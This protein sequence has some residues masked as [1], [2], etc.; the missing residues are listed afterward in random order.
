MSM[1]SNAGCLMGEP[2]TKV[3]LTFLAKVANV[4]AHQGIASAYFATAGDDQIDA[5]DSP[6]TLLRYAE[7]SRITT[8]KPSL[9]KWGVM[10]HA[11]IYCQTG[12]VPGELRSRAELRIPKVRLLSP[13]QKTGRGDHDTNPAYGKAAQ[14]GKEAS[15]CESST[16]LKSMIVLFL[17]NMSQY[18]DYGHELFTPREWGGL[19]LPGLKI[20][21]FWD[22][23]P[24]WK[25]NAI[26]QREEGC[27]KTRQ[28][29]AR[30]ATSRNFERG[31]TSQTEA[32]EAYYDLLSFLP[33]VTDYRHVLSDVPEGTRYREVCKMMK[34]AGW[35]PQRDVVNKILAAQ[36]Y[37]SFWTPTAIRPDR[38]FKT[39]SWKTRSKRICEAY[40][41]I[42]VQTK[43]DFRP[44]E[45]KWFA[46]PW[47]LVHEIGFQ[48]SSE[49]Q[50]STHEAGE[51]HTVP[52]MGRAMNG[53]RV[54]LHY[55]NSRLLR[56]A[57]RSPHHIQQFIN[58]GGAN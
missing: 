49:V 36:V 18:I 34:T 5:S 12:I 15:W 20:Q 7:A 41:P 56:H 9:D 25:Q 1:L 40:T 13:E 46:E 27:Y 29:L 23:I 58:F 54:F 17:R 39:L 33:Q 19:G 16:L 22:Q 10:S 26:R 47:V 50:T 51:V 42:R 57:S 35:E 37:Q 11:A 31:I 6:E 3:V 38:G 14:L 52:L 21:E 2:G 48:F 32:A 45:P 53:P 43:E 44:T 28:I 30:W 8:M 24:E 55:S 4:F